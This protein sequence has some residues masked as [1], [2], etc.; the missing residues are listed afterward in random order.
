VFEVVY[1]FAKRKENKKKHRIISGA[2]LTLIFR[3]IPCDN[4]DIH[5]L[6]SGAS[7]I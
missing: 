4:L 1:F 3:L 7:P 2:Y 5:S 6:V